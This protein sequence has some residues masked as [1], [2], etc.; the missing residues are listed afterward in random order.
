MRIYY[1][2]NKGVKI[3]LDE[4]PYMLLSKNS[5]FDYSWDYVTRGIN[6]PKVAK[7][8]KKMVKKSM[9]LVVSG[10]GSAEFYA[11]LNSFTANTDI[12]VVE[13]APGRIVAG[14]YYLPCYIVESSKPDKVLMLNHSTIEITIL[15]EKDGWIKETTTFFGKITNEIYQ[16]NGLGYPHDYPHGYS[17]SLTNQLL[18]N[19]SYAGAEFEI[20][21]Y[22]ACTNPSISINDNVYGVTTTLQT[23]EYLA[24]NSR[25]RT[26]SRHRNDGSKD[27][28]F[29]AR[30]R[31]F[32]IFAQ[33]P[34]GSLAVAWDGSFT[35]EIKMLAERSEPEWS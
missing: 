8:S 30:N 16:T 19:N 2:N 1:Q 34:S 3:P 33:I 31:D 14:D 27:N 7:F 17:S 24:I 35:F 10:K 20:I 23:G 4:R 25:E 18:V 5:L 13:K 29:S 11:N 22:G 15:A 26:I 21:M 12:D 9:S 28:L 32:D 6:Y